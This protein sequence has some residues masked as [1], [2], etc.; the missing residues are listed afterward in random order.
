MKCSCCACCLRGLVPQ[1]PKHTKRNN[2]VVSAIYKTQM[3][4]FVLCANNQD[5]WILSDGTWPHEGENVPDAHA[6]LRSI[7]HLLNFLPP[8]LPAGWCSAKSFAAFTKTV[9]YAYK[10]YFDETCA[11]YACTPRSSIWR[12][13]MCVSGGMGR[14]SSFFFCFLFSLCNHVKINIPMQIPLH[15]DERTLRCKAFLYLFFFACLKSGGYPDSAVQG[16]AHAGV[17]GRS[18]ANPRDRAPATTDHTHGCYGVR[19]GLLLSAGHLP[20]ACACEMSTTA[21]D[22]SHRSVRLCIIVSWGKAKPRPDF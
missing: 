5:H 2:Q 1:T 22:F 7:S 13:E 11:A 14:F 16:R 3:F 20:G 10:I 4:F 6:L 18:P 8:I 21:V 9:S 12:C 17:S 15:K 19:D